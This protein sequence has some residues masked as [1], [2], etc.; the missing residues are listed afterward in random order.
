MAEPKEYDDE[1]EINN[2]NK[3]VSRLIGNITGMLSD[4]KK[5]NV[6]SINMKM[7]EPKEK[8]DAK[9]EILE[10]HAPLLDV[11]SDEN[12]VRVVAELGGAR[13]D[14]VILSVKPEQLDISVAGDDVGYSRTVRMPFLIDPGEADAVFNNGILEVTLK[15]VRSDTAQII[16]IK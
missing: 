5:T 4:S 9:K 12:A 16:S 1:E 14:D 8:N 15:R 7:E 10:R 13:K 2:F 11:M 6:Y 3:F